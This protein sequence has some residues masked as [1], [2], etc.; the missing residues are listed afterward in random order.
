MKAVILAG[1][2]GSRLRPLT[3]GRP[4]P[5]TPLLGK[6]VLGH[7]LDLLRRHG[8]KDI[9]VTLR[10]LPG[11]VTDFFGDGADYGVKLTYFVEDT[12]L[13][14]AGGVKKCMDFLGDED[15]LVI[16]GDAVCDLDLTELCALHQS[17]RWAASL[18]L[19]RREEPLEYGLVRVDGEGRVLG[20][21]AVSYTHLTLPT[22]PYV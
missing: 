19:C 11:A 22:T 9:A 10:Y 8:V 2:E 13:G 15:F 6:P 1:G 7:I 3:L 18:A 5:M 16:S 4:K 14:T 20:F 12:P 21:V 17:R